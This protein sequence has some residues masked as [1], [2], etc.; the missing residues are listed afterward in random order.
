MSRSIP[1]TSR[2]PF[3]FEDQSREP[4]ANT[5]MVSRLR[6]GLAAFHVLVNESFD[7]LFRQKPVV[8]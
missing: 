4:W 8:L 6:L 3:V 7:L 5:S 2:E 1:G